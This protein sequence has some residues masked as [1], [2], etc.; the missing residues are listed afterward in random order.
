MN[1]ARDSLPRRSE[2]PFAGPDPLDPVRQQFFALN[3]AR[4]VGRN[5]DKGLTLEPAPRFSVIGAM[6]VTI[7][8]L[9]DRVGVS[10]DTLRYYE[11]L[12]LIPAPGRSVNGYRLYDEGV[13]ERLHFIKSAQHMGLR[14]S[15]I[16]ELLEIR[17]RG[18]CPCGHTAQVVERRLAEIDDEVDRLSAMRRE[19]TALGERNQACAELSPEAWW[20]ATNETVR[21]NEKGG[22][23]R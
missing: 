20:C 7:S 11:R 18:T 8:R 1:V 3:R 21:T 10:T 19:L 9:A 14:L 22:D 23:P 16:K 13:A 5:A 17:D 2:N 6:T 12:G 15:D 4:I